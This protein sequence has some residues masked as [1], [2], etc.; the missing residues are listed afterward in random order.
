MSY[1]TFNARAETIQEKSSFRSAFKSRRAIIP[2]TA[3]YEWSG[4]KSDRVP[5][6]ISGVDDHPLAMAG[7]WETWQSKDKS[8]T[9]TSFT[10][11]VCAANDF[12]SALHDRMPVILERSDYET[13]L[14]GSVEQ[15]A[16][17]MKPGPEG[18]LKERTVSKAL[19]SS[20][21]EG[22]ELI[23]GDAI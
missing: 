15:A 1:P 7:T 8:E 9:I 4:P 20:K 16:A 19:N 3:F 13:W 12:M 21:N 6:E 2:A 18:I 11:I 17:L 14:A 22:S 10:I 23:S 5:H